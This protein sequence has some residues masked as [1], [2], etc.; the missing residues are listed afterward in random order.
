LKVPSRRV[1]SSRLASSF[2]TTSAWYWE[3]LRKARSGGAPPAMATCS[4]SSMAS[5]ATNSV[6]TRVPG[7]SPSNAV[8]NDARTWRCTSVFP[9][10]IQRISPP[11]APMAGAAGRSG[12]GACPPGAPQAAARSPT[13]PP[14]QPRRSSPGRV[15]L[16]SSGMTHSS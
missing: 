6:A 2:C 4:F 7:C 11:A 13:A 12:V 10:D 8:P 16:P 3:A 5:A 9:R 15:S 14:I 1:Y